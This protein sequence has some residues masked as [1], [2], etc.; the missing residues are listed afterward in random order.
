MVRCPCSHRRNSPSRKETADPYPYSPTHAKTSAQLA[1]LERWSRNGITT[2]VKPG[3]A[4]GECGVGNIR[5][6][7]AQLSF[8]YL[9]NV[10]FESAV[11]ELASSWA[12][13]GIK[14]SLE[15]KAGPAVVGTAFTPC[16]AGKACP[17]RSPTGVADGSTSPTTTRAVRDLRHRCSSANA[18]GYSDP[19]ADRYIVATNPLVVAVVP[20]HL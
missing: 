5:K 1:R 8:T 15:G 3:T 4:A 16:T 10:A 19:T 9:Y 7:G 13:A 14:L 11:Q 12:Q 20:V 18:G 2:C 6:K 17:W